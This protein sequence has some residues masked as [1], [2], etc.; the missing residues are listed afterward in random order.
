MAEPDASSRPPRQYVPRGLT[1]AQRALFDEYLDR[2]RDPFVLAQFEQ[3]LILLDREDHTLLKPHSSPG[4]FES[5]DR[6]PIGVELGPDWF[7]WQINFTT[8]S[9][10]GKEGKDKQTFP[11]MRTL[12]QFERLVRPVIRGRWFAVIGRWPEREDD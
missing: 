1:V 11:K 7:R 2:C 9:W 4:W 8:P 3:C 6:P 12:T 10:R 5:F